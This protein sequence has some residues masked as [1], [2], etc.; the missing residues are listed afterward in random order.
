MNGNRNGNGTIN[1]VP[2]PTPA[3]AIPDYF[4]DFS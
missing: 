1:D 3:A 2:V 4:I